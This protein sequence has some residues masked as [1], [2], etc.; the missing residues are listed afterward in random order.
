MWAATYRQRAAELREM[1]ACGGDD[2]LLDMAD[3]YDALAEITD[4]DP[5]QPPA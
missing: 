5:S 4:D 1:A 2:G 3:E